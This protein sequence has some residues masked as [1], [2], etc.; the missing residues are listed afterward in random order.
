VK[1]IQICAY[2][3]D[4][5]IVARRREELDEVFRRL[6]KLTK[7]NGLAINAEK[8][9]YMY[10]T[11]SNRHAHNLIVD[12]YNFEVVGEYKY[13]GMILNSKKDT[14]ISVHERIKAA[15]KAYFK[16]YV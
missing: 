8:T 9:K 7:R 6:E 2:A 3:D 16:C 10:R 12:N 5:L 15:N 11:D 14:S 1:H 4:I 13:L